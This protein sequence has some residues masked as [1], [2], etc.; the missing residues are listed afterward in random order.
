[1][2]ST[3]ALQYDSTFN[4][5]GRSPYGWPVMDNNSMLGQ[6]LGSYASDVNH[7]G[8]AD[9]HSRSV[10]GSPPKMLTPQQ[11][12]LKRQTDQARHDHKIAQRQRRT[13]SGSSYVPSPPL[14]MAELTTGASS[15]PIYSS[16]PSQ[17]SLLTAP[18]S[19]V[20]P[21]QYIPSYAPPM[22]NHFSP[23]YQSQPYMYSTSYPT[24]TAQSMPPHYG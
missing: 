14:T 1:M 21:H 19:S 24:T 10:T 18:A 7:L 15:M 11:R 13:G 20:A 6:D 2:C 23:P 22:D 9:H 8:P 5:A 17:I 4:M 3:I 12:D 16:A